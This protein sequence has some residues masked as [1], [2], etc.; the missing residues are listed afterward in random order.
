MLIFLTLVLI[1]SSLAMTLLL[2]IK[3]WELRSSKLLFARIRPPIAAASTRLVR[4]VEHHVP[5]VVER[6]LR[7]V[8]FWIR[9]RVR[10]VVAR[11]LLTVEHSLEAMLDGLK[12]SLTPPREA[13][14]QASS[15]FLREVAEHKRKL[16]RVTRASRTSSVEIAPP[17]E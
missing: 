3:H 16:T 15:V 14:G 7:Y 11:V 4:T 12:H 8:L 10:D 9:V 6:V 13:G 1:C 5:A 17:K 2:Y